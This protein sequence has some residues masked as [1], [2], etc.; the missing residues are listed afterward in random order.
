[1]AREPKAALQAMRT[2]SA[3]QLE[4][5]ETAAYHAMILSANWQ[6]EEALKFFDLAKNG[7][8]LPEEETL[9]TDR[10]RRT[11]AQLLL[12]TISIFCKKMFDGVFS[13]DYQNR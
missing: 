10:K 2:M 7:R 1:M 8:F 6:N 11:V 12:P 13:G 5:P 9:I 4:I 3:T